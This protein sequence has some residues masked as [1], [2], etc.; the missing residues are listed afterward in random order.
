MCVLR[1][2]LTHFNL[3]HSHLVVIPFLFLCR[4][5]TSCGLL[6]GEERVGIL[7]DRDKPLNNAE[8]HGEPAKQDGPAPLPGSERGRGG[9]VLSEL[10]DQKLCSN[11]EN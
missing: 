5:L 9:E 10:N 3:S 7:F 11:T 2:V 1:L 6:A 4:D 8:D